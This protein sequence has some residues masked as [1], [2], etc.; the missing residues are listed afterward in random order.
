MSH[1]GDNDFI[2]YLDNFSKDRQIM[3]KEFID[4]LRTTNVQYAMGNMSSNNF[5]CHK[6]EPIPQE[7]NK[8]TQSSYNDWQNKHDI[9]LDIEP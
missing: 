5:A 4:L 7:Q 9:S 3:R 8:K 2:E 6:L 1:V